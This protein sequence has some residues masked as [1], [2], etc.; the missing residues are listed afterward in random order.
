GRRT[1]A[2][3]AALADKDA[4]GVVAALA[5]LV[6]GWHLAG[7][8]EA[9]PR[10]QDAG[11]LARRLAGTAAADG[12]RHG[13]AGSALQAALAHAAPDGRVLVFGSFHAVA[14]AMGHQVDAG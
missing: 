5:P 3:Y 8:T 2:V 9:G 7:S 12:A 4:V 13:D 14:S 10:G 6:D 11:A 1:L